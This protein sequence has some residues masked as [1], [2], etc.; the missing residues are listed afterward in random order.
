MF[1]KHAVFQIVVL[2]PAILSD[3]TKAGTRQDSDTGPWATN[4]KVRAPGV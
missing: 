1:S 4:G 3:L 2:L